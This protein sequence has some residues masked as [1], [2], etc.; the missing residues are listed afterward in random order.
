MITTKKRNEEEAR[1]AKQ[2][3]K[4]NVQEIK[5]KEFYSVSKGQPVQEFKGKELWLKNIA[6]DISMG[7]LNQTNSSQPQEETEDGN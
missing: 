7:D 5:G 4:K 1:K 2:M 6:E 3:K